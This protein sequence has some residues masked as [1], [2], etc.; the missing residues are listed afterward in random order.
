MSV[1]HMSNLTRSYSCL[2]TWDWDG[3]RIRGLRVARG[4]VR[5]PDEAEEVVQD[6]LLRAWRAR[7]KCGMPDAPTPWVLTIVRNEALRH[8][9]GRTALYLDDMS[10]AEASVED[11]RDVLDLQIDV[12][13]A[14][15]HLD[16][17]D[18]ELVTQRYRADFTYGML[19]EAF[20]L[21][22]GTVKVRL[23][24]AR[25]RL[26]AVLEEQP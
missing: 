21:P 10:M 12:D 18:R 17:L 11:N 25:K 7:D 24:R 26:R 16:D 8:V 5:C 23:H 20:K 22:E 3:L 15:A 19:A 14:L 1:S 4:V 13:R 9:S 2:S 6:A